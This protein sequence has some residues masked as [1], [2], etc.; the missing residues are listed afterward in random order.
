MR[1]R[2][3]EPIVAEALVISYSIRA[4]ALAVALGVTAGAHA[5]AVTTLNIDTRDTGV[6][7]AQIR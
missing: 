3:V 4:A 1:A 2:I 6:D 7:R 5:Q